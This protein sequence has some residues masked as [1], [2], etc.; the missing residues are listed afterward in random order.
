MLSGKIMKKQKKNKKRVSRRKL[1][2]WTK[3]MIRP[4]NLIGPYYSS[5]EMFESLNSDGDSYGQYVTGL[6]VNLLLFSRV[7]NKTPFLKFQNN[8]EETVA[9]GNNLITVSIEDEPK[10]L[11][12]EPYNEEYFNEV[13][14]WIIRNKDLLMLLWNQETEAV[15]F[16]DI[17]FKA[18]K[19]KTN[20]KIVKLIPAIPTDIITIKI[21][22]DMEAKTE[23]YFIGDKEIKNREFEELQEL[24]RNRIYLR[25]NPYDYL[26]QKLQYLTLKRYDVVTRKYTNKAK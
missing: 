21:E 12:E 24:K 9:V 25:V 23:R 1:G 18:K 22:A 7:E 14:E 19:A 4:E 16:Y 20:G 8:T 13:K 5:E 2:S 15:Y 10:V 11:S 3:K 26:S 17:I 6:S